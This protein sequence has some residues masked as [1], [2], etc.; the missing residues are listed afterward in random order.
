MGS[1]AFWADLRDG[2]S[3]KPPNA[4]MNFNLWTQCDKA[5]KASFL[6]IGFIVSNI[7]NAEKLHFYLP[8]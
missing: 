6:D 3:I 1:M 7:F 8:F 5:N 2:S 4:V